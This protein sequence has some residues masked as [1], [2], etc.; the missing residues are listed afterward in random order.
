MSMRAFVVYLHVFVYNSRLLL[1]MRVPRHA[2]CIV[3]THRLA[4]RY[5]RV[6]TGDLDSAEVLVYVLTLG[7]L[8]S[9]NGAMGLA[10]S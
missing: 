9:R 10:T 8:W 1:S 2:L 3:N 5:S 7:F 6:L 4:S